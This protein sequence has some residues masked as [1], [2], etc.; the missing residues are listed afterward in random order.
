MDSND[1]CILD[2]LQH[3]ENEITSTLEELSSIK[4]K[5]EEHASEESNRVYK[6]IYNF[7][8]SGFS[9]EFNTSESI[10]KH[11][12]FSKEKTEK[13]IFNYIENLSEISEK[14]AV[15]IPNCSCI[16]ESNSHTSDSPQKKRKGPKPYSEMTPEELQIAKAKKLEHSKEILVESTVTSE[17]KL[18]KPRRILKS[19][20]TSDG[21]KIW[22]SF[23]KVVKAELDA[24]GTV[25]SYDDLIKKAKEMKEAD[26]S[27]Y[28]LFSATWTPDDDSS[29]S[30]A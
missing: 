17:E 29:S 19:K 6:F 11:F 22:N 14:F 4:Y 30:N 12:G 27:A 7:N 1:A 13:L 28:E 16:S 18:V 8:L 9:Q 15:S 23:L 26:K 24:A 3:I 20:K 5:M 10:E 2:K 25:I 21:I